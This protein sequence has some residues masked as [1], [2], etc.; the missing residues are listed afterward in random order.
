MK[1][2]LEMLCAKAEELLGIAPEEDDCSDE[3]N[4][5]FAELANL[6][7]ALRNN[8]Y[9]PKKPDEPATH[10]IYGVSVVN[11]DGYID[12]TDSRVYPVPS[13]EA[14]C[15]K[16][17]EEYEST[18]A[19]FEDIGLLNNGLDSKGNEKLSKDEFIKEFKESK[20]VVI[21]LHDSRVQFEYFEAELNF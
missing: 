11:S 2:E 8:G 14:A 9:E 6:Y 20:Y 19:E 21:L 3:E 18:W 4:E 17:Y 7:N 13:C 10:M 16:A 1:K 15:E 12:G 5:V